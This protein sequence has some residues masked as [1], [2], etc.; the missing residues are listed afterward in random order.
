VAAEKRALQAVVAALALVP[1]LAGV[2]GVLIGPDF[3]GIDPPWPRDLDSHFRYLSGVLLAMG[4]AWWSCVPAID[5][6]TERFRL[7]AFLTF[8]GGLARLLSL[9]LA[10]APGAGHLVGLAIETLAVPA[11][12]LWQA[13]IA[14]TAH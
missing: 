14:A 3:L 7:L 8:T 10:G 1:V 4:V 13:R 11:L 12:T 2:A 9:D 5:R 6:K